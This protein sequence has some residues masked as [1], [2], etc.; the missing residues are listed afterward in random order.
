MFMVVT[1]K[2][3]W[4]HPVHLMKCQTP[5]DTQHSDQANSFELSVRMQTAI[6]NTHHDHSASLGRHSD[7]QAKLTCRSA[8]HWTTNACHFY[9]Q[10]TSVGRMPVERSSISRR[11]TP[12]NS[13]K[14]RQSLGTPWSGQ[15][16]YCSC[17]TVLTSFFT[18]NTDNKTVRRM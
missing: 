9:L 5:A 6:V 1:P 16:V 3:L 2:R 18:T 8:S 7:N 4:V 17:R 15:L 11:T 13:R 10:W 12:T 14:C